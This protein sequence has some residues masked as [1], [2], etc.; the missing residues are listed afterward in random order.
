MSE[1]CIGLLAVTGFLQG[2]LLGVIFVIFIGMDKFFL[3]L[4]R[5]G[6]VIVIVIKTPSNVV[7]SYKNSSFHFRD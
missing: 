3:S 7:G 1:C 4:V 5:F 2:V 6:D